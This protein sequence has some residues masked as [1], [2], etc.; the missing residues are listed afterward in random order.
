MEENKNNETL[1]KIMMVVVIVALIAILAILC[2]GY[3]KKATTK[4][5]N[6]I[7]TMEVEDYG[8]IKME[9]YPKIAPNTVA[10]FVKLANNG[11]YN[12]LKFHRV[13]KDFMIQGGD[14]N[15]D[16][17][18]S[19]K[20]KNLYQN[21]DETEY[22]IKGE[23]KANNFDKNNLN[24]TEGTIAMARA[25]YTAY[26]PTLA[27]ESYNSAGTQF[28]I[29]TSD[30][31]TNLSGYYAGFGK[32]I[33]GMDI[34]KKISEVETK[35]ADNSEETGNTEESVPTK[36]VKIKS[37]TVDTFGTDYGMPETMTPFNYMNWLYS[38]YGLSY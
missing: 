15:G 22:S 11:F 16:G 25:D 20:L 10:N 28:F 32:V 38:Q 7:V 35:K 12:G 36:D 5:Q 34:V 1:K 27:E 33:E 18:G 9:L 4:V 21:E 23:M 13:V 37:V 14:S 24:L 29:M 3:I 19:A 6:P 8:T 17:T 30:K 26:S 31:H 2:V